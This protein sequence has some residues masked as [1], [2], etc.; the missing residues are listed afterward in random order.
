MRILFSSLFLIITSFSCFADQV[1]DDL[2]EYRNQIERAICT[3]NH[4]IKEGEITESSISE[5]L[6]LFYFKKRSVES[7][8]KIIERNGEW[9]LENHECKEKLDSLKE[10][11]NALEYVI[12]ILEK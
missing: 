1:Q 5:E 4:A 2:I 11:K 9:N 3:I 6:N 7:V 8:L 12:S 10:R